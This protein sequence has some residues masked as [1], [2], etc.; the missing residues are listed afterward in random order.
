MNDR[1]KLSARHLARQAVVYQRQSSA[2]QVVHN[3]ESTE[4]QYALA[5]KARDHS[6]AFPNIVIQND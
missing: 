1:D 3:R 4:R 2:A 6:A 5:T